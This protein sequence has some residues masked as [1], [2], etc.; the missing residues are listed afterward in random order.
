MTLDHLSKGRLV[1]PVGLGALDDG[2][3]SK[4][5]EETDLRRRAERLD[6]GLAIVAALWSGRPSSFAGSH[7]KI[8][9]MAL[10]PGSLQRPRIPVWVVA[11]WRRRKS[12]RRALSWDGIIPSVERPDGSRSDPSAADVRTIAEHIRDTGHGD[13]FDLVVEIS[14]KDKSQEAADQIAAAYAD[15]GAT[16]WLDPVWELFYDHP[17]AVDPLR[18]RILQGPPASVRASGA[19]VSSRSAKRR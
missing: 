5:N 1:L 8:E 14:T 4:V 9:D 17:G 13:G 2:A 11:L 15:A 7:Y 16:W 19:D 3:F 6:E 12:V 18:D 10:T